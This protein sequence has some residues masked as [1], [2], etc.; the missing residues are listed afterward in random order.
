MFTKIENSNLKF[1]LPTLKNGEIKTF[2]RW[3]SLTLKLMNDKKVY[4]VIPH[5]SG[6]YR[7]IYDETFSICNWL[8]KNDIRFNKGNDAPR[9]GKVGTFIE[10]F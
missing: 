4:S 8:Q 10:V 9:G 6:N 5:G 2:I 3:V 7:G 1:P